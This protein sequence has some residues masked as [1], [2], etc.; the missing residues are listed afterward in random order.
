MKIKCSGVKKFFKIKKGIF[1]YNTIEVVNDLDLCINQGEIIGLIGRANSGK[2]TII[3]LLSGKE[4]PSSGKVYI[5]EEINSKKLRAYSEKIN[6]FNDRKLVKH[7][8]VYNNL[9]SF[10]KKFKIDEFE[11]EKK[12]VELRDAIE[13]DKVINKKVSELSKLD[14]IKLNIA[15]SMLK[16]PFVLFFDDALV[17][18]DVITKNNILKILKR[19]NKEFK[20][21]IVVASEDLMDVEK[22]CKRVALVENGNIVVD[23]SFENVKKKYWNEKNVSIVFNKSFNAPKGDFD[24]IEMSD[25]FI[26][27]KIDFNKCDFASLINQ[28]DINTIID[29]NIS[30]I[31]LTS[32]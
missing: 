31:S 21:T 17:N 11:I 23:D 19:I 18:F 32:L 2:S 24:I 28:F 27:I 25:Y 22:I 7:D 10:G 30:G 5:D 1:K 9:V 12:I 29:I 16:N 14:Q 6:D 15:I 8:S 3:N 13:L 20:T 4:T 26:K